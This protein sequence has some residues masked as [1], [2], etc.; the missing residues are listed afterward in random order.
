LA[1]V[2]RTGQIRCAALAATVGDGWEREY[3]VR[4]E[5]LVSAVAR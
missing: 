1:D 4:K 3:W 2:E 5:S